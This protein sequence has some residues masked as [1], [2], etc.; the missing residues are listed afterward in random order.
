MKRMRVDD[1]TC[2]KEMVWSEKVATDLQVNQIG[3]S[4][5]GATSVI[6]ALVSLVFFCNE[7]NF[8]DFF[9]LKIDLT[10]I[11]ITVYKIK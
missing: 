3:V 11:Y 10:L 1:L 8:I 4:A 7:Y 5:C 6:N 2:I 9:L